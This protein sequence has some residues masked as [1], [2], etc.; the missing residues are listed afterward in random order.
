M[1]ITGLYHKVL[2]AMRAAPAVPVIILLMFVFFGAF[3]NLLTPHDPNAS[4][5]QNSL[6]PPFWQKGGSITYPLGT[7]LQGRDILSRLI[8]GASV[9][10]QVGFMAVLFAGAI[11]ITLAMIAG[12]GG[13]WL[14]TVIMRLVD[15]LL[16]LPF[17]LFAIVLAA[18]LGPSKNNII[19]VLGVLGWATYTRILRS[20]V[21]RIK[22][23]DFIRL[24]V[25]A[26]AN[27]TRIIWRHIFPNIMNSFIILAT[28]QL[29]SVI[30]TE[31]SL[32]FLGIGV[33]PP[34]PSWGSM[35]ADGRDYISSNPWLCI[36]PGVAILLVVLSCN[37]LGD[38]LRIRLDP[39]F[40][41]L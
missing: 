3:G 35:L 40:R 22:E 34:D 21:L 37:L 31:S 39:K 4:S 41:Q 36:W 9:S 26:G 29:G 28:L 1:W 20:E 2:S 24:A 15:I 16:S 10:L 8:G 30:I 38:W 25:V 11:G 19:L 7:D 32:S 5:L 23:M 13:G 6:M 17:L 33:P 14:D 27:Q 12:Y 18:V